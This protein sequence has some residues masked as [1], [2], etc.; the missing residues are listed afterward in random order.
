MKLKCRTHKQ[1]VM[2]LS[3]AIRTV[4][5]RNDGSYCPDQILK[6]GDNIIDNRDPLGIQ[7]HSPKPNVPIRIIT[8]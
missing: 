3:D 7:V 6:L 1:R 2:I 5:H 8:S 4:V